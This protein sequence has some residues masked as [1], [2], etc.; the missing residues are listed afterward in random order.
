[1]KRC[2]ITGAAGF[3]AE[4][5]IPEL[6]E[7]GLFVCGTDRKPQPSMPCDLYKRSDLNE[8]LIENFECFDDVDT[9]IHLA[10][11][12]A[13]WGVTDEEFFRD[14]YHATKNLLNWMKQKKIKNMVFISSIS[15]MP[16]SGRVKVT[17]QA[18]YEPINAYGKSKCEAEKIL[19]EHTMQHHD[20]A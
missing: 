16:Q 11:A 8:N 10:A 15:V 7:A 4:H 1:M 17:E 14:N 9:V 12:S 2:L 18:P 19:I 5:L 13:D 20:F 6:Q 3:V